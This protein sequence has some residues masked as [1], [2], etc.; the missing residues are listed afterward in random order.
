MKTREE[1]VSTVGVRNQVTLPK[2]V[3]NKAH[4]AGRSTAFIRADA[5][6]DSL[7]ITPKPPDTG[8]YNRIKISEKGQLV[9]PRNLRESKGIA[10]STNLVFS[11]SGEGEV[12]VQ[13]LKERKAAI[14]DGRWQ[15]LMRVVETVTSYGNLESIRVEGS[16]SRKSLILNFKEPVEAGSSFS[17][18][19]EALE[20]L[21][22]VRFLI[23]I[24]PDHKSVKLQPLG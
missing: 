10:T 3:R 5:E 1:R 18:V 7:I 13:K 21:A 6:S 9:I 20:G 2:D 24:L 12:T 17:E 19:L 11:I 16:G 4:I 22:D 15:F 23:E 14:S 8:I